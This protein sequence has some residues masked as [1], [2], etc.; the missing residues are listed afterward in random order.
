MNK[1]RL[2]ESKDNSEGFEFDYCDIDNLK[3]SIP[4]GVTELE[5]YYASKVYRMSYKYYGKKF[6]KYFAVNASAEPTAE[7]FADQDAEIE[8]LGL[9][10]TNC[11]GMIDNLRE[12]DVHI[13]D[14]I[15]E[16]IGETMRAQY[17]NGQAKEHSDHY[18]DTVINEKVGHGIFPPELFDVWSKRAMKFPPNDFCFMCENVGMGLIIIPTKAIYL[19]HCR[20]LDDIF[21]K[22]L[23]SVINIVPKEK[24]ARFRA[25]PGLHRV[26]AYPGNSVVTEYFRLITPKDEHFIYDLNDDSV[27]PIPVEI[28]GEA[29]EEAIVEVCRN[30]LQHWKK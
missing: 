2:I 1:K 22:V 8:E 17:P 14:E 28:F 25:R 7:Y 5:L 30:F 9:E 19:N 20:E 6:I 16:E 24:R 15:L 3:V 26:F 18:Y 12:T 4:N 27:K 21:K 29:V 23:K 13:T 10:S 11:V